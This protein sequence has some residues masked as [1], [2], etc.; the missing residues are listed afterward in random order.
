MS[1][2]PEEKKSRKIRRAFATYRVLTVV[3]QGDVDETARLLA[4][5]FCDERNAPRFDV[6]T[7]VRDGLLYDVVKE[8][9]KF[10]GRELAL[11][12]SVTFARA[13][14]KAW[15]EVIYE[16]HRELMDQV[17]PLARGEVDE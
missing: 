16:R 5:R 2:E 13:R 1:D 10:L 6:R 9:S 17:A 14:E 15:I 7:R 4:E 3:Q 11:S 12:P 8:W